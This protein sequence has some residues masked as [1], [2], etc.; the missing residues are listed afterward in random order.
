KGTLEG[1]NNR[2]SHIEIKGMPAYKDYNYSGL[3]GD[4]IGDDKHKPTVRNLIVD[5]EINNN[6]GISSGSIGGLVGYAENAIIENCTNE[7]KIENEIYEDI[8]IGGVIG[9]V[10]NSKI[11]NLK[12]YGDINSVR[13]IVGGVVGKAEGDKNYTIKNSIN[14]GIIY[15]G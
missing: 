7:I 1:N 3:F 14:Y 4:L 2:I 12:N 11:N 10:K 8:E 13:T 15:Q 9:V 5:G 6:A